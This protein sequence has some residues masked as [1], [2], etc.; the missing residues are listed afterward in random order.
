VIGM[1][2]LDAIRSPRQWSEEEIGRT[3]TV[4]ELLANALQRQR[5]HAEIQELTRRL[6]AENIYLREAVDQA[7][8]ADEI[9]GESAAI[10]NVLHQIDL[11]AS[12]EATVL[13]TGET[14]TGKEL[15]ARA[16]HKRSRRADRALVKVDCAALPET[17]I[18]SALFGHEKGAFTGALKSAVGR[19]ELADG[20]TIFLDEIGDL[21][22]AL[23]SKLLRVLQDGEFE[24]VGS[25]RTQRV[26]VRAIAATNRNLNRGVSEGTFRR[27]LFYRLNVFPIA[28][29]PLRDRR[30]DVPL[31]VWHYINVH[32]AHFGKRIEQVEPEV[33][34]SLIAY[35]WPGNVRE[36]QNVIERAMIRSPGPSLR[37]YDALVPPTPEDT[38]TPAGLAERGASQSLVD[39]QRN[40]IVTVLEQCGWKIKGP[41]NAAERL[42][43]PP[44]TLRFRMKKFGIERPNSSKRL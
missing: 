42:G 33:M 22:P 28:V 17:L 2:G 31:L 9:V 30:D 36:L 39:L 4:G 18:E 8:E 11:V 19:F 35:D 14:G 32:Q 37:I 3:R 13:I 40:H 34:A 12:A 1:I 27:D 41:G 7:L 38:P 23:Q 6:E 21:S 25:T 16:I 43:L 20:G 26:D 5:Q 29:P 44:S 15:V 24:R 10:S